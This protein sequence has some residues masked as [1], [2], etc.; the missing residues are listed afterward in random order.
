MYTQNNYN[1]NLKKY[2]FTHIC[3]LKA[4]RVPQVHPLS[5]CSCG[6]RRVSLVDST[7][8][9]HD[10]STRILELRSCPMLEAAWLHSDG[11]QL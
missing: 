8:R 7:K 10:S 1:I 9:A 3:K 6:R 5:L 11:L 4:D 2:K